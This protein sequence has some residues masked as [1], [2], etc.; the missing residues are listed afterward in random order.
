[1]KRKSDFVPYSVARGLHWGEFNHLAP[2]DKKKLVRLM[3]RIA[4]KSYRRGFEHGVVMTDDRESWIR[5]DPGAWRCYAD[6][7]LS[8]W[9]DRPTTTTS[10]CRLFAECGVLSEIGFRDPEL[11][12]PNG[13]YRKPVWTGYTRKRRAEIRA[14]A[15]TPEAAP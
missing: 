5:D 14:A 6:L 10:I 11:S 8:P 1:M 12:D 9:A 4:E 15:R 13:G 7:D 3:A 2:A